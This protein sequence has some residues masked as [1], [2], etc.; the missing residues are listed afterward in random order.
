MCTRSAIGP[1]RM[2]KTAL[3]LIAIFV[4]LTQQAFALTPHVDLNDLARYGSAQDKAEA[5]VLIDQINAAPY[6]LGLPAGMMYTKQAPTAVGQNTVTTA[7]VQN[8]T[9]VGFDL[10][11]IYTIEKRVMVNKVAMSSQSQILGLK[12]FDLTRDLPSVQIDILNRQVLMSEKKSG[13]LKFSPASMGSLVTNRMGDTSS[14]Y[15]TLSKPFSKAT[16][17]RSQSEYSR[18]VPD[19]YAGR[20]FLRVIDHNQS[21]YGGFTAFG[22]HYQISDTLLRGFISN[23]CFRLRDIDLFELSNIVFLTKKKGVPLTV[24]DS[25]SNGNRHPFPMVQSWF[26]TPRI[27]T[28]AN[29]KMVFAT[30]E[31]GLYIFDKVQSR[32]LDLLTATSY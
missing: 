1:G 2:K 5:K 19:Y 3:L 8:Q 10:Y 30:E 18:T 14:G 21:S 26:N 9:A 29:G 20:P 16:L 17:S 25:T 15:R 13:L 24:V 6:A 23:G 32:P 12:S 11:L 22:I 28:D 31:H 7:L 27:I 4:S